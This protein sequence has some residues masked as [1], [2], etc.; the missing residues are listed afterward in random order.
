MTGEITLRGRV[1]PVGGIKEKVLGALQAGILAVALP[2]ENEPDF[3]EVPPKI[4]KEISPI[5]VKSVDEVL[6][7]VLALDVLQ[8]QDVELARA[9][10]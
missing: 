1:L 8:K 5:Y 6:K 2:F 7:N 3:E 9:S 10:V 4:R